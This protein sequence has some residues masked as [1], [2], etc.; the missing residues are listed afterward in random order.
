MDRHR[1]IKIWAD[2]NTAIIEGR[3]VLHFAPERT[4]RKFMEP[5]CAQYI[6][7]DIDA[8]RSI[9]RQINIE[10]IDAPDDAFDIIVCSHVLEHVDDKKALPELC[11]VLGKDG[12]LLAMAPIID[13]WPQTYENADIVSP[14][15]RLLH[16]DQTDHVRFYGADII[17]RFEAAGFDVS[18]MVASEPEVSRY[19]LLR[20]D[21]LLV[22]QKRSA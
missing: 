13:A 19:G 1:L 4:I 10:N 8:H 12:I 2:K 3:S 21:R 20:G 17:Q 22:C 7:A 14:R 15:D 11:R 6:A 18:P 5:V 16:F 9:D